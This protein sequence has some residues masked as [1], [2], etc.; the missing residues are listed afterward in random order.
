MASGSPTTR[1][2]ADASAVYGDRAR[3]GR[4]ERHEVADDAVEVGGGEHERDA[5]RGT[6]R[7]HV[8]PADR[9]V[10]HVAAYE[11]GVQHARY[12]EVVDVAT[13]AREQARILDP[14][15]SR[16]D[17]RLGRGHRSST[18]YATETGTRTGP[19]TLPECMNS[20]PLSSTS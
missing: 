17:R 12:V 20:T 13:A 4:S 14:Q 15:R 16:A 7:S 5:G 8:D 19:C 11:R 9:A 6:R 10:R 18:G 3:S 2:F 1:T